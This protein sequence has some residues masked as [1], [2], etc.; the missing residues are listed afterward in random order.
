MTGVGR[1][2]RG[3]RGRRGRRGMPKRRPGMKKSPGGTLTSTHVPA[4]GDAAVPMLMQVDSFSGLCN[5]RLLCVSLSLLKALPDTQ[6]I[7]LFVHSE[8]SS[9]FVT[10]TIYLYLIPY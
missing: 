2:Q 9:T 6:S 4:M 1:A 7:M 3:V 8:N 5:F 10:V